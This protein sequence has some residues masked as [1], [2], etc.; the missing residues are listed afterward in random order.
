MIYF[1]RDNDWDFLP[2]RLWVGLWS[3]LFLMIIVAFDLS[4]L[5]RYITRFTEESFACLIAIIFI[6][7]SF[8][9]IFSV[10]EKYPFNTN[11]EI[12]LDYTCYCVPL[13][14][15]G[16]GGNMTT[17]ATNGLNS[18]MGSLINWTNVNKE[19]CS[20][21]G[22][23]LEGP[24]CN[25]IVYHDNVFFLSFILG[26]GTFAI[27]WTLVSMKKSRFFP[28]FVSCPFSYFIS[29]LLLLKESL[30]ISKG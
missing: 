28:T 25:T 24:G 11:P 21:L 27:A 9:K 17:M 22:G 4:A 2:F 5:V 6:V 23:T 14:Q 30:K 10:A 15:T 8:K 3:A 19:D 7:E 13:N 29:S 26:I 1:F 12:P 16:M 18:T 20:K